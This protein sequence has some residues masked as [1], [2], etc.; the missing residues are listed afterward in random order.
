[1]EKISGISLARLAQV[2]A[3][4]ACSSTCLGY[5]WRFSHF[6]NQTFS[7]LWGELGVSERL[8]EWVVWVM[9]VLLLFSALCIWIKPVRGMALGGA[10]VLLVEMMAQTVLPSAKYPSLYWAEWALRYTAPGV[11]ILLFNTSSVFRIWGARIIQL[12]LILVFAA[13][14]L[15][16]LSGDPRFIDYLLVSLG[17]I[18]ISTLTEAQVVIFLNVIGA[19]DLV[20]ATLLIFLKSERRNVVL[21]WMAGWGAITAFSRITYGGFGNGHEVFIRASHFLLPLALFCFTRERSHK[22]AT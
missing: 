21:I 7:L 2:L 15:V 5:A 6:S 12:A 1:M 17:R 22:Q 10:A 18:G 16:A 11:A 8:A 20:A 19:L 14:G 4:L 9:V 3:G 13:H